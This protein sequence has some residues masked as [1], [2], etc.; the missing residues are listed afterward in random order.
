M[1][2]LLF[3]EYASLLEPSPAASLET[4]KRAHQLQMDKSI[5]Y[6]WRQSLRASTWSYTP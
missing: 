5:W 6:L 1:M 2:K 4:I 3:A